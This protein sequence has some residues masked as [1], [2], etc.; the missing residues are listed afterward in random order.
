MLHAGAFEQ[1]A[2]SLFEFSLCAIL[3]G[4]DNTTSRC[5]DRTHFSG[6][7]R[8]APFFRFASPCFFLRRMY[9]LM[10]RGGGLF[11]RVGNRRFL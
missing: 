5:K 3:L 9:R 7:L 8:D 2:R 4:K 1:L 11:M 6:T 10:E